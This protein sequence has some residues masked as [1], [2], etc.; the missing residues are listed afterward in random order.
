[1]TPIPPKK[2]SARDSKLFAEKLISPPEPNEKLKKLFSN[3]HKEQLEES[4][5]NHLSVL[6]SDPQA[7]EKLLSSPK[8]KKL[9]QKAL[10]NAQKEV[11]NS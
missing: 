6:L 5:S 3:E 10:E 11:A 7:L 9:F 8:G 4:L 1:M 2:L